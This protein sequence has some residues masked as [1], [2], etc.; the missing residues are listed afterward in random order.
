MAAMMI[1]D[2]AHASQFFA[3]APTDLPVFSLAGV[4]TWARVVDCYDGD[5]MQV[6]LPLGPT[7]ARF[8][9]RLDGIDAWEVK[10]AD[11][12]DRALAAAARSRLLQLVSDGK[13]MLPPA[14]DVS[15][16]KVRS[17]LASTCS[18]VHLDCGRM[19]KYGRVLARVRRD[20]A[21]D[22][23]FADVLLREGLAVAY[24]GGKKSLPH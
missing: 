1:Q 7:L 19:D 4:T 16:E 23:S 6:V 2:R 24:S 15:R 11:P 22:V 18:V 17:A 13:I 20:A 21:D 10:S 14:E 5:T 8:V 12:A 9:V 3:S